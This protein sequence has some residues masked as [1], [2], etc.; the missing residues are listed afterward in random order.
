[1]VA[2]GL[3]QAAVHSAFVATA[4][5]SGVPLATAR[6]ARVSRPRLSA[7]RQAGTAG[8]GFRKMPRQVLAIRNFNPGTSVPVSTECRQDIKR[9]G[10]YL[11]KIDD[12]FG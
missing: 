11:P 1:L 7:D 8:V 12:H 5:R 9:N 4:A 10:E 3:L 2:G 6:S